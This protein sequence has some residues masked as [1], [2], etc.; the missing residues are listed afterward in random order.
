M[1]TE[2]F[3]PLSVSP[4]ILAACISAG[5]QPDGCSRH[6]AAAPKRNVRAARHDA[7]MRIA[8]LEALVLGAIDAVRAGHHED[9]RFEFKRTWPGEDKARQ[10]AGSANRARGE[11]LIY[12]IG[13][14]DDGTVV[15]P[16]DLD[17]ATW[18][19]QLE[20]RFDGP[21]PELRHQLRVAVSDTEQVVALEFDTSAAPYVVTAGRDGGAPEREVPIRVGTRTRSVKREE[22]LRLLAPTLCVPR[23]SVLDAT[24]V[25]GTIGTVAEV[26]LNAR[27]Y[28]EHVQQGPIFL[29]Q[30]ES[31][32]VLVGPPDVEVI[33]TVEYPA[34]DGILI[35]AGI[36]K[37][38]VSRPTRGLVPRPDGLELTGPGTVA[39]RTI[40][41]FPPGDLELIGSWGSPRV[42]LT[43]G[44]AGSEDI[45]RSNVWLDHRIVEPI[46]QSQR[47]D[48][49]STYR[50]RL[51]DPRDPLVA[52]RQRHGHS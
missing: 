43:F 45:A 49:Q 17:P 28:F 51:A 26:T 39:I 36:R 41:P 10:L 21:A 42:R 27:V 33:G 32:A 48:S 37:Q 35:S 40:W 34:N 47:S 52:A 24:L 20:S 7:C 9:D 16:S 6:P 18:F 1:L 38:P 3:A 5:N 8:Q 46:G 29:P 19:S 12:V 30:H 11:T 22:L 23:V 50:W 25:L 4:L 14:A 31:F 13:L 44:I 15:P 2:D